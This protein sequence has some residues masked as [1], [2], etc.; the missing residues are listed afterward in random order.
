MTFAPRVGLGFDPTGD[1]KMSIRASYGLS[2]DF[3]DGQYHIGTKLG[4]P[5]ANEVTVSTGSFDDPWGNYPGG[6][7]F[8]YVLDKNVQ[9][10]QFGVFLSLPYDIKKTYVQTWNLSAGTRTNTGGGGERRFLP[11]AALPMGQKP[12]HYF[13]ITLDALLNTL[14][15]ADAIFGVARATAIATRANMRAYSTTVTPFCL[16]MRRFISLG[17]FSFSIFVISYK[18]QIELH[19]K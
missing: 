10:P 2:Y 11:A 3:V 1:G 8:P 5:F 12:S 15:T 18:Y 16:L 7:P 13:A 17:N 9:Y 4:P 14:I 19:A 6:N